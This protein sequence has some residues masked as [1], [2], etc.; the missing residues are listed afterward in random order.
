MSSLHGFQEV[1]LA[2][3]ASKA[4][5]T[6]TDSVVRFNKA[7]AAEL[8]YP[9]HVHIL[10]NESTKQ[11]A[12][13]PCADDATNAIKFSKSADKQAGSISIKTPAVLAAVGAFFE[14]HNPSEDEIDYRSMRGVSQPGDKA[15]IFSISDAKADTM[16]K[17]GRRKGATVSTPE[18]N[19]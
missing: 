18:N 10:I 4:V 3:P 16:K 2:A 8:G 7:T 1:S 11:I 14:L 5:L 9:T 15:I 19:E 6:V 13:Q 17:R 12:V